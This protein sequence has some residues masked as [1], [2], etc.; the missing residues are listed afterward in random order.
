MA[1]SY[2][3]E[4]TDAQ[5]M[6]AGIRAYQDVL[7]ERKIDI[8]FT[9]QFE[10]YINTCINLNNEQEQLKG[11][12]KEKTMELYV[13][14]KLLAEKAKEARKVIKMDMPQVSWKEFGIA[15]KR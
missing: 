6:V 2:S 15:D 13:N 11:R 9:D 10:S 8:R 12:L 7:A 3:K 1:K 4:I 14:L 5:V